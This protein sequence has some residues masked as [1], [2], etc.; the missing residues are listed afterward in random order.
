MKNISKFFGIIALIAII[1]LSFNS[2]DQEVAELK[3]KNDTSR[4]YT[5]RVV[6]DGETEYD[7][8]I[9]VNGTRNYSRNNSFSYRVYVS[10]SSYISTFLNPYFYGA[11]ELGGEVEEVNISEILHLNP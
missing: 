7:G 8:Q 6:I 1:G 4:T 3:I 11:A 2:C 9:G 5:I 10:S